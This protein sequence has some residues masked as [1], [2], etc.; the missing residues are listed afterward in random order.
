MKVLVT[1]ATGFIGGNLARELWRRGND[2]QALVRPDSNRLTIKDTGILTVE[3]DVLDRK[4]VDRAVQ[5]CEAVF[6]V[7]ASYTFWS[8]DPA[9][10]SRTN[11]TGTI[12]VLE[13]ARQAGVSRTV[14][15]STVGTIGLSKNGLGD[16]DTP[17]SP[18]LLHGH[19]KTSKHQAELEALAISSKEMP[20]VVVNPTLPVGPWDVKPT[21]T[22]KIILDFLKRKIPAYLKTGINVIDVA[23]VADGHI[24]AL[25]NGQ[26]G[27]R[28][29]LGNRNMTLKELFDLLSN[30]TGLSTPRLRLPYWLVVGAGYADQFVEGTLL[31][32]EPK[33]PVEG[34]LASKTPAYVSSDKAFKKFGQHLRPVDDA[35]IQSV[36]WFADHG[37]LPGKNADR[38]RSDS[39]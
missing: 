4:S 32:R 20:V 2:V 26:S 38:F 34:V 36:H 33:I 25:E 28:Y 29:I 30:I 31:H 18:G 39:A 27:E 16:E 14:Y 3:G 24:L 22:G 15:T 9:K 23:D 12:N 21:P 10:V 19:Y 1:G 35:L 37:Y 17:L 5:G 8:R 11:V 6:H 7:A 13:A